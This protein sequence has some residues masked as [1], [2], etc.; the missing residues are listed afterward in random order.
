LA[1]S[2]SSEPSPLDIVQAL[3]EVKSSL[4][5][6]IRPGVVKVQVVRHDLPSGLYTALQGNTHECLADAYRR[7]EIT[8][9]ELDLWR[10]WT[11]RFLELTEKRIGDVDG[12][13]DTAVLGDWG[14]FFDG[15][16][17]EW[18]EGTVSDEESLSPSL[19]RFAEKIQNRLETLKGNL[20]NYGLYQR[21]PIVLRQSTGFVFQRGI[22]VTTQEVAVPKKSNEWIRV[23]CGTQVAYSTGELLGKDEETNVA[24]IRLASPGSELEPTILVDS[25]ADPKVGSMIY[26]FC[27]DFNQP[28][29]MWSGEITGGLRPLPIYRCAS[30]FETSF[31]T[32][33]GT[34]GSPMVNVRGELVGM[35]T[36]FMRQGSMS[37]VTYA[38]PAEQLA[39]VTSQIIQHGGVERACIGVY[40]DEVT[41][42]NGA[43][44]F[45]LVR[46]IM[47]DSPAYR[48][49]VKVGDIIVALNGKPVYCRMTLLNALSSYKPSDPVVLDIEREGRA[50]VVQ[51]ELAPMPQRSSR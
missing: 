20:K 25:S 15:V 7:G 29:S 8:A 23:Y 16:Y 32:S 34:L 19:D 12:D 13:A 40:V 41:V 22:V 4:Y 39:A 50:E 36:A 49:G 27:H 48:S 42:S 10:Q 43:K 35:R 51:V 30:F 44:H 2:V 21:E 47:P 38:L 37:E 1:A 33:P 14:E 26:A 6:R 5:E 3:E 46:G 11:D 17:K 9:D 18:W 24:V 28:L 31:P 45:V